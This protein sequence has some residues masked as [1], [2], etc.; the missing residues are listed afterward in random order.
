MGSVLKAV[1][2]TLHLSMMQKLHFIRKHT[3]QKQTH[4]YKQQIDGCQMGGGERMGE[5]VKGSIS[6]QL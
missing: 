1:G 4:R 3:K 2:M 5:K 6:C